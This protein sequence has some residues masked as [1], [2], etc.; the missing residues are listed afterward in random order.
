MMPMNHAQLMIQYIEEQK[1]DKA[2][3]QFEL[4]KE[5]SSDEEKFELAEVLSQYGF[6]EEARQLLNYC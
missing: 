2:E 3:K 5:S 4:V 1:L 6:L